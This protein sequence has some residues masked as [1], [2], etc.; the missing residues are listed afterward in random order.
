MILWI[1]NNKLWKLWTGL[2]LAVRTSLAIMTASFFQSGMKLLFTPIFTRILT[3]SEYGIITLF[4]SV[5][6]TLGTVT[7]LSLSA[8]VY[9]RGM[10]EFKGDRNRFTSSLLML[11]NLC[12]GAVGIV[13]IV[14]HQK[15]EEL[16]GLSAALSLIMFAN[17][18]FLPAYNF[19]IARQR[20]EY[21]YRGLL[22]ATIL[23]NIF[24]PLV[25][26]V[27]ILNSSGDHAFA[28]IAGSEIVLMFAYIPLYINTFYKSKWKIS[29]KYV[30]YG[31]KFNLPLVPH[32]AS[33]QILSSCDRIMISNMVDT[34]S[35]GV[36]GLSYQVSSV[37][38]IVW[39]SINTVLVPWEYDKIESGKTEDIKKLTRVLIVAYGAACVGVMFVA[40]EVIR[41]FAP[42]SYY[43]GI[44][45]M[46][47]VIAGVF[48][49]GLY[50]L[51]AILEFYYKK[52]IYVMA[53]SSVAA[54]SNVILN[55]IFIPVFGYQAAAYT[56]LACYAFYALLHAINLKR[57]KIDYFY[58]MKT[59]AVLSAAVILISLIVVRT[60][61]GIAV[62]YGLLC[63]L[64]VIAFSKRKV[65]IEA[66]VS[67]KKK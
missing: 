65:L 56:T 6:T 34:A 35:A 30:S 45:V 36:Y 29:W 24:S 8:S 57:L 67:L 17:F 16:V 25:A 26:V 61:D 54:V 47:P 58:D 38:R 2:S 23:L 10:Q 3:K 20:F 27:M 5:Q 63:C 46:A 33:Q 22:I 55:W 59:I 37:I 28:K 7:M 66:V 49:S 19:W 53:A 4:D 60:Y 40:P 11:S 42:A 12:T 52:N 9:S 43:E 51:L 32:Y 64:L 1:K 50:S 18:F 62:R 39:T 13:F 21:R 48:F 31:L 15:V 41:I 14:F 44:Y